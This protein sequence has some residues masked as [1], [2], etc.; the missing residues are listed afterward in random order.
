MYRAATVCR[1][2]LCFRAGKYPETEK[3]GIL[4]HIYNTGK[5]AHSQTFL[6]QSA[7]PRLKMF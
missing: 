5:N 1:F 4:Y 3:F 7:P 2:S 6:A